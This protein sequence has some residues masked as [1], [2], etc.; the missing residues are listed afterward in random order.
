MWL[1]D[2]QAKPQLRREFSHARFRL[3]THFRLT[4]FY[5]QQLEDVVFSLCPT[6]VHI[7]C[8]GGISHLTF[9]FAS[10]D[11]IEGKQQIGF[12]SR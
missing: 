4:L 3:D 12:R 9:S 11:E 2:V 7:I 5:S 10:L 1:E 8:A 6:L